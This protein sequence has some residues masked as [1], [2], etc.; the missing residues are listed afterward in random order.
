MCCPKTRCLRRTGQT[1]NNRGKH[2]ACDQ[3]P[4]LK[5]L[6]DSFDPRD[7]FVVFCRIKVASIYKPQSRSPVDVMHADRPQS[8]RKSVLNDSSSAIQLL[9]VTGREPRVTYTFRAFTP[10]STLTQH[11]NFEDAL[12][13]IVAPRCTGHTFM[14]LI[15]LPSE[16]NISTKASC[17]LTVLCFFMMRGATMLQDSRSPPRQRVHV[18]K[19]KV[20]GHVDL[21]GR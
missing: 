10:L 5:V 13:E 14:D 7:S 2:L 1:Y 20:K 9:L 18:L 11:W 21:I 6:I 19:F 15:T 4:N 12:A 16:N 8:L 3:K 17:W